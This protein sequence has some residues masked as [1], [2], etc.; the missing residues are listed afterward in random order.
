MLGT[1]SAIKAWMASRE[2]LAL[3]VLALLLHFPS[4]SRAELGEVRVRLSKVKTSFSL[5]GMNLRFPGANERAAESFRAIRVSWK[6]SLQKNK[7]Y[8]FKV[9]DR[10]TRELLAQFHAQAFEVAGQNLRMSLKPVP[11][12]LS[13]V[14]TGLVEADL[15]GRMDLETYLKGVL[16]AEMPSSWPLEALKAQAVAART[17]ALYRIR[18]REKVQAPYHLESTVMDQVFFINEE[19]GDSLKN[20]ERAIHE[21]RGFVLRDERG[22][23]F[24]AYFHADCGGRTEEARAVWGNG[25]KLGTAIDG[26]CPLS[27]QARWLAVLSAEEI[28]RRLREPGNSASLLELAALTET[29]SG[30]VENLALKWGNGSQTQ[31]SGHRFRMAL[32]FDRIKSTNFKL[33]KLAGGRYEF[34]GRGHGHGVGLC[35]WGSRHLALEGRSFKEILQHYYPA[36]RLSDD[37]GKKEGLL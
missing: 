24:A 25:E 29:G 9:E 34:I 36:A 23:P 10:D 32:G 17:F 6:P 4:A 14:P 13:V 7:G 21:T 19:T 35:Q 12:R 1:R 8:L 5:S 2:S 18:Q 22:G 3:A 26:A 30:R 31:V 20:A 37:R 15:I 33:Q 28:A 27:P 16:P 11:E